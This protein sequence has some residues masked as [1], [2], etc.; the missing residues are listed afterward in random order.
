MSPQ[1]PDTEPVGPVLLC[2]DGSND[3]AAAIAEAGRVLSPGSAVVLAVWEP[4]AVWQPYDPAT[5]LTAPVEKLASRALGLDEIAKELAE[6]N[7]ARGVEL[8]G[9]A[10][11]HA[12]ARTADGKTWRTI[13]D[14]ATELSAEVVVL[15]ARGLG[16]I[17]GALLGGVSTAV[18][19][20]AK[21]PVLIVPRQSAD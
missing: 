1:A 16:R 4:V 18:V 12:Q 3:A 8:A 6:E 11:F 10:G 9:G 17:A 21:R 7:A 15:G 20:H 13:C 5:I 19:L 14:V 2:F